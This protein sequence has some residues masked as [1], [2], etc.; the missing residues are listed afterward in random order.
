MST[1]LSAVPAEV[2]EKTSVE[3]TAVAVLFSAPLLS[4]SPVPIC[5]VAPSSLTSDCSCMARN[6][7]QTDGEI[8]YNVAFHNQDTCCETV[9]VLLGSSRTLCIRTVK[10]FP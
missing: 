2:D 6:M 4:P 8:V 9:I 1:E 5:L 10:M 3:E 7:V